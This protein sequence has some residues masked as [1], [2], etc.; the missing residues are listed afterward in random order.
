MSKTKV[1]VTGANGYIGRHVVEQLLDMGADVLA[2]DFNFDGVDERA[3]KVEAPIF[4]GDENIYEQMGKPDVCIHLAW[5]NGF[6]HNADSHI[7]DLPNHYTFLKN[8]IEGGLKHVVVMG[9]MHEVGY[10]EGAIDENT[11]TNPLSLYGIAKNALRQMVELLAKKSEVCFQWTRG[12]YIIGDDIKSNSIFSKIVQAEQA[13]NKKFPFTT[14]KNLYDFISLEE[15]AKEIACVSLQTEVNGIINCCTGKPV[16]LAEQVESFIKEHNF[17][18][19][20][21]Y[22]AYPDRAYDSPGVWGDAKKIQQIMSKV[23]K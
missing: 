11:P 14:G 9:T 20:L 13:G 12:Y 16:S 3:Q 23:E 22:G 5:R 10:W 8:M 6:V 17:K 1:L 7:E 4:S 21:E 2:A 15:L 19:R 18:I